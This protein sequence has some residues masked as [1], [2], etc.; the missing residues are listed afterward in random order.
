[1]ALNEQQLL[2]LKDQ[3]DEAKQKV[4]ELKGQQNAL[5][6]QLA[7]DWK[8][9][10]IEEAEKKLK[11]METSIASIDKKIEKGVFELEEKYNIQ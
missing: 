4:S 7:D 5:N 9:K 2:D 6:K 11:E 10:T 8:C 3:V 1:M